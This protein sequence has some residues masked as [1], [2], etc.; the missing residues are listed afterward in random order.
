MYSAGHKKTQLAQIQ[1]IRKVFSIFLL[2]QYQASEQA[3]SITEFM[4]TIILNSVH[5]YIYIIYNMCVCLKHHHYIYTHSRST[6]VLVLSIQICKE[7]CVLLLWKIY[8]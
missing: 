5:I 6:E 2:I 7:V 3:Q 1:H 4:T 8:V